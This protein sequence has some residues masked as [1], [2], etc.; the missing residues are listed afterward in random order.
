MIDTLKITRS[1]SAFKQR[2]AAPCR[3]GLREPYRKGNRPR[4][5]I[6]VL[7]LFLTATAMEGPRC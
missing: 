4:P 3:P 5:V 2:I 7:S 6:V 1:D